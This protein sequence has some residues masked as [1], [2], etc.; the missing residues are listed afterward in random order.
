MRQNRTTQKSVETS[1][2]QEENQEENQEKSHRRGS[3]TECHHEK[4]ALSPFRYV[5]KRDECVG[6][7]DDIGALQL[8]LRVWRQ[9]KAG[10]ED[11]YW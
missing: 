10:G 7:R 9:R 6:F 11:D 1:K 4:Q 2:N 8:H 3:E 5:E